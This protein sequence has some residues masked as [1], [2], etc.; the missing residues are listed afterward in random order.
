MSAPM[1][2]QGVTRYIPMFIDVPITG[3]Y[4]FSEISSCF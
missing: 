3:Y 2:V 1:N 4:S